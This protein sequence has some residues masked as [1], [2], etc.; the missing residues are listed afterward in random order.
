MRT[1]FLCSGSTKESEGSMCCDNLLSE[2]IV[3]LIN[4]FFFVCL[5]CCCWFFLFFNSN[6]H[7]AEIYIFKEKTNIVSVK[8]RRETVV[9]P[10]CFLHYQCH[11][12][13]SA[14]SVKAGIMFAYKSVLSINTSFIIRQLSL[15]P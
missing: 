6:L 4:C 12:Y 7:V 5:F 11:Q 2:D 14:R 8:G 10:I 13:F 9:R 3:P 1:G 15:P